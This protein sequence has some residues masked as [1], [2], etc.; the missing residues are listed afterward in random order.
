M[1]WKLS[2]KATLEERKALQ[3][4]CREQ[5]KLKLLAD[6]NQDIMVCKIEGWDYK[7]YLNSLVTMI[8]EFLRGTE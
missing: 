7:E 3:I 4:L 5:L 6:I 2:P 8:N 1:N